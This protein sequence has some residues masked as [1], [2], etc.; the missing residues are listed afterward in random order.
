MVIMVDL[1]KRDCEKCFMKNSDFV[2]NTLG[3]FALFTSLKY[4]GEVF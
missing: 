3:R 4:I 2:L 1:K